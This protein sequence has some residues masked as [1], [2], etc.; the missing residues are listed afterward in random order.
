MQERKTWVIWV[1]IALNVAMFAVELASGVDAV[2]PHA[3]ELLRLGA[4]Y[5]PKT[6]G[7]H[8][9]WR[10]ITSMFLHYGV[11]HIGMNMLC[12]WQARAVETVFGHA[13]FAVIYVASGL[14]GGIASISIRE[15]A[16]SA[17]ASGAVFGVFGAFGAFLVL[18][19]KDVDRAALA[20]GAQR[21]GTFVAIN[22]IIGLQSKSIDITAHIAGLITGFVTGIAVARIK[23]LPTLAA[24]LVL[25]VA[26]LL[27]VPA[28]G[29]NVFA[30][31]D[32]QR[33]I[34]AVYNSKVRAQQAGEITAAQFADAVDKEVLPQ[35][36]DLRK[37]YD[38]LPDTPR[39][40][41]LRRYFKDREDA[42]QEAAAMSR[43]PSRGAAAYQALEQRVKDDLAELKSRP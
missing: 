3:P 17:G 13:S 27:V 8:E 25:A 20:R 9:W 5:A 42:I 31:D 34:L 4:N 39:T 21:L 18:G 43:D 24:V 28:D 22:M 41:V 26:A 29:T 16:V 36:R 19:R 1:L 12:L 30:L 35:W 11:I 14:I 2:Q 23:P 37:Q 38:A 32:L 33:E 40:A 15:N 10:L 6:L 7:H